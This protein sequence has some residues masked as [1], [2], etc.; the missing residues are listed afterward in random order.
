MNRTYQVLAVEPRDRISHYDFFRPRNSVTL[1]KVE[2][3]EKV[4]VLLHIRRNFK[5]GDLI[6]MDDFE[7][8]I[9]LHC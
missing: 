6:E 4:T 1:V 8:R 2:N 9:A 7:V 3:G 5:R